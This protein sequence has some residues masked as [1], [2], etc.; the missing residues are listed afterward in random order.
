LKTPVT[1]LHG[2]AQLLRRETAAERAPSPTRLDRSLSV[3]ERESAKLD[4][5]VR[6]LLDVARI[7]A[8]KLP[9]EYSPTDLVALLR[10]VVESARL[11]SGRQALHLEGP[12]AMIAEVDA[13]RIEQ[14]MANVVDNALKYSPRESAVQIT[15]DACGGGC[16]RMTVRDWGDGI[17]PESRPHIF[18]RFYQAH[19]ESH[20]SGM[21]LGL[22]ICRQIVELHGGRIWVEFPADG[23]T[24]IVVDLPT[25]SAGGARGG[26]TPPATGLSNTSCCC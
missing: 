10:G 2:Y 12:A 15:V 20:T 22:W 5:L 23:G 24:Q 25:A 17:P 19:V 8:G 18:D 4:R 6:Q 9:V 3:I 11:R 16:V 1:N 26:A 14:V 7:E 21:G 13:L